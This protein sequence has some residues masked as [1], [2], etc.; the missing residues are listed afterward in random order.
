MGNKI[1]NIK[2]LK[3]FKRKLGPKEKIICLIG[4][5]GN[6]KSTFINQITKKNECIEGCDA[7]SQTIDP[8]MVSY[9]Y[10]GYNFYFIDTPGLN[11]KKGDTENINKLNELRKCPRLNTFILLIKFNDLRITESLQRSL[12]EFM[13]IFPSK[14]FWNNIIIVRS[15]SFEE[16]NKGKFLEGIKKDKKLMDFMK[17]KNINIPNEIK[18]FYINLKSKDKQRKDELFKKILNLIKEIHPIYK[19]VLIK[20]KDIFTEID[21][22]LDYS[23]EKTTTYIDFDD[24]QRNFV[25]TIP[26]ITYNLKELIPTLITVKREK[27][28]IVRSD[29]CCKK[30]KYIYNLTLIYNIKGAIYSKYKILKEAYEDKDNDVEG[31]KFREKLENEQNKLYKKLRK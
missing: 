17:E 18:E 7:E 10:E 3:K 4:E 1:Y 5:T 31:E 6:G 27:T 24:N 23:I 22:C 29:C 13:K 19:D 26:I 8:Q 9:D 12:I 15:W 11:D 30:Y 28:N 16:E 20:E 25:E 2:D 14:N 21:G